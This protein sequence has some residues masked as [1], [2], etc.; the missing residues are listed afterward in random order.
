[1]SESSHSPDA[2]P[3]N[4][5]IS[6]SRGIYGK[7]FRFTI[8]NQCTIWKTKEQVI[9]KLPSKQGKDLKS[10]DEC[11]LNSDSGVEEWLDS[12]AF[13]VQA[14]VLPTPAERKKS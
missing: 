9:L 7:A 14:L 3:T 4:F 8:T 12:R 13:E 11:T 6:V 1:M 2:L 5:K 10:A